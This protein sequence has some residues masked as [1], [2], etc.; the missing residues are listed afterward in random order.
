MRSEAIQGRGPGFALQISSIRVF[1]RWDVQVCGGH[2]L[3]AQSFLIAG[4]WAAAHGWRM[5]RVCVA[6]LLYCCLVFG[7]ELP[8]YRRWIADCAKLP[9]NRE[10][11]G[12]LPDRE[13]LPLRSFSDFE[14]VLD[15]FLA[16]ERNGEKSRAESWLKV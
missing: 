12:T 2:F 6:L 11:R 1:L 8:D 14:T 16:L 3:Q 5:L 9:P 7:G 15:G 13:L 10:L 4:E